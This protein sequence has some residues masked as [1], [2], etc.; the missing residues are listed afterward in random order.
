MLSTNDVRCCSKSSVLQFTA[1]TS[2][3][4]DSFLTDSDPCFANFSEEYSRNINDSH[5]SLSESALIDDVSAVWCM[6][7]QE[8]LIFLGTGSGRL[9]IWNAM[10]GSLKVR[11]L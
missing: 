4:P 3:N 5:N 8:N 1:R 11:S 10:S 2:S 9:E 6:D 7:C